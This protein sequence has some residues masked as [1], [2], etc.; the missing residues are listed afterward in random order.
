V[1]AKR[2]PSPVPGSPEWLTLRRSGIGAT[3]AAAVLGRGSHGSPWTK[4]QEMKGLTVPKLVSEAMEW[5]IRLQPLVGHKWSE[6]TG[7]PVR[8]CNMTYWHPSIPRVY[9]HYDFDVGRDAILEV[10]TAGWTKDEEWGEEDSDQ[11]PEEYLVQAQHELMCRPERKVCYIAVLIGG[12]KFRKYQVGRDDELIELMER[13]YRDFLDRVDRDEPPVIDGSFAATEF[14]R[15]KYPTD[16]GEVVELDQTAATLARGYREAKAD[17]EDAT[18]RAFALANGLRDWMADR[19]VARSDDGLS[20]S[21][22][23][24][25]SRKVV[26]WDLVGAEVPDVVA[27]HT[28]EEPGHRPLIVR[29][30]AP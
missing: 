22:R 2:A 17:I 9:S 25:K 6:E 4:Y 21:Y 24:E 11:V 14:L 3:D 12:Q 13:V 20:V 30:R 27:R 10:K 5:G 23:Q 18:R 19:S 16:N 1:T 15:A 26:D 29:Y 8:A 7:L 28:R